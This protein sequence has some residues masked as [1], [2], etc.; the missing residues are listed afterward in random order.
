[1]HRPIHQRIQILFLRMHLTVTTTSNDLPSHRLADTSSLSAD[2]LNDYNNIKQLLHNTLH[3]GPQDEGAT[4]DPQRVY[5]LRLV[6]AST[7]RLS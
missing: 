6:G 2:A 5:Y 7:S 1:M 3:N 4:L